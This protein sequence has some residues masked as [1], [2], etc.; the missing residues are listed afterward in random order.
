MI[1]IRF[2]CGHLQ[3]RDA[4]DEAPPVCHV[5]G[6]RQARRVTAP[7][8]R[9]RGHCTGPSAT[10]ESLPPLRVPLGDPA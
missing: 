8:P 9:F 5:C 7:A 2:A 3:E 6:N 1:R 4:R 10:P